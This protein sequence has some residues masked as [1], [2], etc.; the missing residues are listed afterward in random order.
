M[1]QSEYETVGKVVSLIFNWTLCWSLN[2][3]RIFL[4]IRFIRFSIIS[5]IFLYFSFF[6]PIL[7]NEKFVL[8]K[9]KY[10]VSFLIFWNFLLTHYLL[11]CKIYY[12]YSGTI[13]WFWWWKLKLKL[14]KIAY[15]NFNCLILFKLS[16]SSELTLHYWFNEALV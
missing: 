13:L 3:K 12:L 15:S 14:F 2:F 10:P 16:T 7:L 5:L 1:H 6:P 11:C 9:I 8:N 4:R